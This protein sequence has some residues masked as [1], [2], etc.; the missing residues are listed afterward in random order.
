V[1][2][3]LEPLLLLYNCH[4][5]V[6]KIGFNLSLGEH[7]VI[8]HHGLKAIGLWLS[9][10]VYYF[11]V[12]FQFLLII[13]Q[14]SGTTVVVAPLVDSWS[15]HLIINGGS[16]TSFAKCLFIPWRR[17]PDGQIILRSDYLWIIASFHTHKNTARPLFTAGLTVAGGYEQPWGAST[18]IKVTPE[19]ACVPDSSPMAGV[20][21]RQTAMR[22]C[23][24][25][26]VRS[27]PVINNN[28]TRSDFLDS[29]HQVLK[30]CFQQH[31]ARSC[32]GTC[33]ML[34]WMDGCI[35]E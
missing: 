12:E 23:L 15:R 34:R 14:A 11:L 2:A 6:C 26:F 7:C 35:E 21:S 10:H 33:T 30:T 9:V 19:Q 25:Y 32:F 8:I 27:T 3:P 13:I 17:L 28:A 22:L 24:F 16:T 31:P 20:R 5:Q 18:I 1:A 4:L 29:W